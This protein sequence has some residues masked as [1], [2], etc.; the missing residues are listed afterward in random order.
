M[1]VGIGI[2][3]M[4]EQLIEIGGDTD[5]N[6]SIAGQIAGTL[7]GR[8]GI[9]E[10]LMSQLTELHEFDW[11]DTTIRGFIESEDWE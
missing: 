9:P 8:K 6:A 10:D 7:I 11:I 5:T 1:V 4:Y 2:E 3:S